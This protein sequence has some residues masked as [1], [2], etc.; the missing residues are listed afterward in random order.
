MSSWLYHRFP[1]VSFV[2][3]NPSSGQF[4]VFSRTEG[5]WKTTTNIDLI[6][7]TR[8]GNATPVPEGRLPLQVRNSIRTAGGTP[9]VRRF[10]TT[11]LFR[12]AR[13]MPK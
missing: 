10:A 5:D 13:L 2:R 8:F 12:A 3:E 7:G 11:A 6:R 1:G 4:Q 9:M